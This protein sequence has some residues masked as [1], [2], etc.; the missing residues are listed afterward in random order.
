[1]K[2]R[3]QSIINSINDLG[4]NVADPEAWV[5]RWSRSYHIIVG[6]L[7]L[8]A[9]NLDAVSLFIDSSFTFLVMFV[10]DCDVLNQFE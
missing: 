1:L 8:Y 6:I 7:S 9:I 3:H 2:D 5:F 4:V 10:S